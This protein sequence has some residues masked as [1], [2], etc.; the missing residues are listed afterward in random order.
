MKK[1]VS[2][3]T[4]ALLAVGFMGCSNGSDDNNSALLLSL[5]SGSSTSAS[6]AL[7]SSVGTNELAGKKFKHGA[8]GY[9]YEFSDSTMKV[10]I[11][12]ETPASTYNTAYTFVSE[13]QLSYSYNSTTKR[14]YSKQSSSSSYVKRN[15]KI[16]EIPTSSFSTDAQFV[17]SSKQLY[18][19]LN[20]KAD[21]AYITSTAAS[22]VKLQRYSM[23]F[24]YGYTDTT[25]ETPVADEI[26]A[27]YNRAQDLSKKV[28]T[29][30]AYS[31]SSTGLKLVSDS[32]YPKGTTLSDF[33]SSFARGS[34]N[35]VSN[36]STAYTF[37]YNMQYAWPERYCALTASNSLSG[38]Q[39]SSVLE[40]AINISKTGIRTS[41]ASDYTF[42]D[43]SGS[44]SLK[45]SE[46][47]SSAVY[48]AS[49]NGVD[50]GT[51][52]IPYATSSNI[53]S[54]TNAMEYTLVQ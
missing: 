43:L 19:I 9:G 47:S 17:D 52:T 38:Y 34:L 1:I 26:I 44:I 53:P 37:N 2:I 35:L 25:G 12:I 32:Y 31:L 20:D 23:F 6:S 48:T 33:V 49:L 29:C 11:E 7:P 15:G 22:A 45:K 50:I 30:Q 42:T 36:S 54:F 13:S 41:A 24:A 3:F 40:S 18:K 27:R 39:V 8:G 51:I 46:S 28:V 16:T 10:S 4:V 5:S 14:I 21:D